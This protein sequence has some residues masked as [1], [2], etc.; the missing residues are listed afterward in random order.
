MQQQ[1]LRGRKCPL[2]FHGNSSANEKLWPLYTVALQAFL[3]YKSSSSLACAG[4]C[5]RLAM[6][7]DLDDNAL[8]VLNK[9]IFAGEIIGS[10]FV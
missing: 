4:T 1:S 7:A 8:Q 2:S 5:L 9:P 6:V 10:L 3:L